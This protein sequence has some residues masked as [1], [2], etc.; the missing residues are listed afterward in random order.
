MVPGE[1]VRPPAGVW[2]RFLFLSF[3]RLFFPPAS[4]TF[5]RRLMPLVF[6]SIQARGIDIGSL[7][8][9]TVETVLKAL[10]AVQV[11]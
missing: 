8:A 3:F 9:S 10:V 2:L 11:K 4:P 5:L 6:L 7:W 1:G